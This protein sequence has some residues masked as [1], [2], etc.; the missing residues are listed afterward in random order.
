M[1]FGRCVMSSLSVMMM[2]ILHQVLGDIARCKEEGQKTASTSKQGAQRKAEH[3][4][5]FTDVASRSSVC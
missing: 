5:L 1:G 4:R 3:K 2:M